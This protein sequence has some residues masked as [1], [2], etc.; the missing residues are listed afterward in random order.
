MPDRPALAR[1]LP[2]LFV[3]AL[4]IGLCPIATADDDTPAEPE[5]IVYKQTADAKGNPVELKLYVYKPEGWRADDKR[6]AI[7]CFFGG[8]WVGG[9]PKQFFPH[10]RDLAAR[11]MV[12]ISAEYRV[13]N[14]HGTKPQACVEDGKSAVRYLRAHADQL[15]IDA[16]R[17]V[18]A[19]GSAGGHV[20]ACT[21]VIKGY[22]AQGED[23]TISSKP[24]LMILFNPVIDT[25]PETGYGAGRIGD[26]PLT[27]SPLHQAHKAQPPALIFH[28]DADKTVR[29]ESVRRFDKRCK[30]VGAECKVAEYDGAG[31]GFFN[32][33]D[34]RKRKAGTP[35]YYALT[36]KEAVAFLAGHGYVEADD[37]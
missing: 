17:I 33:S 15:G 11:G 36:M 28:G 22:E 3:L 2:Q 27:L 29:I 10:C 30:E 16:D 4:L 23:K 7:V 12:A 26:D 37:E 8:G 6:P 9:T 18:S 21:G 20:A 35:N 31:H 14:T 1:R 25:S 13:K 32:H 19:G 24:N 5:A 34:F